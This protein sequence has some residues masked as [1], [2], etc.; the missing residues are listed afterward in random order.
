MKIVNGQMAGGNCRTIINHIGGEF[1][2]NGKTYKNINGTIEINDNGV[3]VNGKPIEEWEEAPV[4]KLVING[5]VESIETENG[6]VEVNGSVGT[7]A[8]KNGNVRCNDVNGNVES[9]NGNVK[10]L[11][12]V[13]GDVTSKNG[14]IM[15]VYD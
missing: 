2:C 4:M 12:K 15:R 7:V 6:D 8:S 11:G 1:S 3:F 9:K 14:N 13:M 10:I 5:N